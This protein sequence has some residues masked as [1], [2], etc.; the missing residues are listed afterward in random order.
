MEEIINKL[1]VVIG[2]AG[3]SVTMVVI[4][5][6]VYATIS[7]EKKAEEPRDSFMEMSDLNK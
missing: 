4:I 7:Q 3:I 1:I 5:F 2:I 6:L